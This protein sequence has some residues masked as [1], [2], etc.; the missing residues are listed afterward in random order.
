MFMLRLSAGGPILE[1]GPKSL[2]AVEDGLKKTVKFRNTSRHSVPSGL[3]V[4][5]TSKVF[6]FCLAIEVR[7]GHLQYHVVIPGV[8]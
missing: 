8:N 6:T 2:Q 4:T 5:T 3:L 7:F 1:R